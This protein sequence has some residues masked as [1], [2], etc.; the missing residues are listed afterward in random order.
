M[1]KKTTTAFGEQIY[2]LGCDEDGKKYWLA[3]PSWD[4]DWYW[5]FGYVRTY[6]NNSYPEKSKDIN[7][8][9]HIGSSFKDLN[10]VFAE[11]TFSNDEGILLNDYFTQ[12][13]ELKEKAE[14]AHRNDNDKWNHINKTLLPEIFEKILSIL[15]P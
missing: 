3:H 15:K 10:K 6:T 12:F 7:S 1:K 9:E 14:R 2:L 11:A 13:Y 8:H 5:G 4:L